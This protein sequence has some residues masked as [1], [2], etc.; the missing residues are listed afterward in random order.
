MRKSLRAAVAIVAAVLF[1][2]PA[3]A[4]AD[5]VLHWN[6]IA[7]A[8]PNGNPFNQARVLAATQLAVFEALN[9]ITG[10]YEPYVGTVVAP[11]G[12]SADAAVIAA[13]HRMLKHYAPGSAAMLDAARASS[14]AAIPN[15]AAK[16]AG[17]TV[18]EAGIRTREE[19][20]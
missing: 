13:A 12:A 9:A 15:G 19:E 17:V 6:A 18:G 8:T 14:L 3:A 1:F 11:A 7:V 10:G 2:T 20:A 16:D 4:Q 5:V